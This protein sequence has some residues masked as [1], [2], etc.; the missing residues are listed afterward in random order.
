M[1][2]VTPAQVDASLTTTKVE[3]M[4]KAINVINLIL[5]DFSKSEDA[6]FSRD[7]SGLNITTNEADEICDL[8]RKN[9][10]NMYVSSREYLGY[11]SIHCDGPIRKT[12]WQ[13]LFGG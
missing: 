13:R 3:R 4:D 9:G 6:L 5:K 8:F 11:A 1:E 12:W 2:I 7:L 10:W